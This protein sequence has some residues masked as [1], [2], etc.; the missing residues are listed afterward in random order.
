MLFGSVIIVSQQHIPTNPGQPSLSRDLPTATSTTPA[1][2]AE[3]QECCRPYSICE[4]DLVPAI[5]VVIS[6]RAFSDILIASDVLPRLSY[7]VWAC[8]NKL[9][10]KASNASNDTILHPTRLTSMSLPAMT[11][12]PPDLY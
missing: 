7:R 1:L 6:R 9:P 10:E 3:K 12:R 5:R 4:S 8:S 11:S 2:G